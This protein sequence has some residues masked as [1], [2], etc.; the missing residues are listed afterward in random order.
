MTT[1]HRRLPH[2]VGFTLIE[3]LL[4]VCITALVGTG[5]ATM[6][7]VLSRDISMQYEARGVLVRT[8]TAQVRLSSYV[9]PARHVLG[10]DES[11]LVLWLEDARESNT[12]HASEIRWVRHDEHADRLIVEFV[13]FPDEWSEAAKAIADTEYPADANW[14]S[15]RATF[16]SGG[17]LAAAPLVDEIAHASF[18]TPSTAG[19]HP[20]LVHVDI[21]LK[22]NQDPVPI[23][24]GDAIR[25]PRPP[26]Q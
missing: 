11:S 20:R 16:N 23:Q 22:T 3:T 25:I 19:A 1:H 21:H 10:A 2:R 6:M 4:A 15:V 9:A 26:L 17:L 24:L 13:A 18:S 14:D 8:S 5:I 12:V 7:S